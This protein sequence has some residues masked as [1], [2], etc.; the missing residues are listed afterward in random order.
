VDH[1][2]AGLESERIPISP[3]TLVHASKEVSMY[4]HLMT[5]MALVS[6][7]WIGSTVQAESRDQQRAQ[8]HLQ[9]YLGVRTDT[10]A[11]GGYQQEG[12]IVREVQPDG[13][14]AQAGIRRGDVITQVGRRV[15]ED[16]DDL[17][18]AITRHQAGDRVT[19]QARR[20]GQEKTFR[21]NLNERAS[22]WMPQTDDERGALGRFGRQ[23]EQER[24]GR[25]QNEESGQNRAWQRLARR[26]ERLE[27]QL[28]EQ[29]A[30]F[31]R[32]RFGQ[33]NA[34][35]RTAFL[36]VQTRTWTPS[37]SRRHSGLPEEG[38]Q[39]T[40]VDP[41]SAADEAGLR[42][43]DVIIA[44]NGR[45]IATPQDLRQAVQRVGTGREITLEILRGDRQREIHVRS[46]SRSA[47]GE[48]RSVLQR[49]AR[50]IEQLDERI[51]ERA[52]S[53]RDDQDRY[54]RYQGDT[55]SSREVQQIQRQIQ[56]LEDRLREIEHQQQNGRQRD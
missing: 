55:Q 30:N 24:Y 18:N 4:K 34:F 53:S 26:I 48:N 15:V 6:L 27:E 13:P 47:G 8:Q 5:A 14:A 1:R 41:N 31:G 43:G 51:Q 37:A 9:S 40:Q 46:D 23:E 11:R 19:I 20:N 49:L 38:V 50:Q 45:D 28:Q 32:D 29:Q 44:V 25:D 36:G 2:V 33:S 35:R 12:V 3:S 10:A 22:R 17:C 42:Q 7:S 52:G 54:G 21:V 16:F 39:I 56:R